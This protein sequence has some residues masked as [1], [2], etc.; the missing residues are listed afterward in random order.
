MIG[1]TDILLGKILIVDDQEANVALLEQMLRGAG[2]TNVS[3]TRDS[4]R[5]C[6]LHLIHHYDLILLDL[7]MPGMDGFQVM[8][9]LKQVETEGYL[10]VLVITAQP[11]HK[12]RALKAGAKDFISKPL[13]LAEV[14][15]RVHNMLEVRLLHM[16]TKQLYKRVLDEQKVSER[17][18]RDLLPPSLAERL[19]KRG[20]ALPAAASGVITESYAEVTVLFADLMAFTTFVE[21]ANAEVLMG[22]LDEISTRFDGAAKGPRLDPA[23]TIGNAYLASVGLS[24]QAT[25]LTIQSAR[26]ALEVIEAVDRFNE[27]SRYKLKLRVG[28]DTDAESAD[29]VVRRKITYDL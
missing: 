12:V 6:E 5:V 16:E 19:E 21:G 29:I 3:M 20:F 14:L 10:P 11:G 8:E 26:R 4:A 15:I 7:Q 1:P 22:V 28:L 17:L 27:R 23:K 2:Y 24:D 25:A 18:L 13:D 9:N